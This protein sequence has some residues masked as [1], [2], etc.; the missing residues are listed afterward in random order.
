MPRV[1]Y[2]GRTRMPTCC[3]PSHAES[4]GC[5]G[6]ARAVNTLTADNQMPRL[7]GLS[8]TPPMQ[9]LSL[10]LL[11]VDEKTPADPPDHTHQEHQDHGKICS[12]L[13]PD[14]TK[15]GQAKHQYEEHTA[16][17]HA[18]AVE[19]RG[20]FAVLQDGIADTAT[21]GTAQVKAIPGALVPWTMPATRRMPTLPPYHHPSSLWNAHTPSPRL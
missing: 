3:P 20:A 9:I 8:L 5:L 15:G 6:S 12:A 1:W 19:C 7:W 11:L 14:V 2:D 16:P 17:H 18:C 4:D 13:T 21:T 10:P